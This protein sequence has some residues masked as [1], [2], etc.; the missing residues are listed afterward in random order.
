MLIRLYNRSI[1]Y[2]V[3]HA[4]R[5]QFPLRLSLVQH[6]GSLQNSVHYRLAKTI[7]NKTLSTRIITKLIQK[8]YSIARQTII[9]KQ[10]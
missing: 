10:N 2:C 1:L 8:F 7:M 6:Y 5:G 3:S 9:N 4:T